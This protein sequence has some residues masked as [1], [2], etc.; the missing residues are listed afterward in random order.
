[1]WPM[2]VKWYLPFNWLVRVLWIT[3][4]NFHLSDYWFKKYL[5]LLY[6]WTFLVGKGCRLAFFLFFFFHRVTT[7][8]RSLLW[9][10]LAATTF[11][12][13]FRGLLLFLWGRYFQL[14]HWAI[15]SVSPL[16]SRWFGQLVVLVLKRDVNSVLVA[17]TYYTVDVIN[18][19]CHFQ[20]RPYLRI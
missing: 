1:M 17:R 2:H 14:S 10:L 20:T 15:Q 7:F 9:D 19:S 4:R 16:V 13:Y 8:T 18:I 6:Y 12:L 3:I 11:L 5:I